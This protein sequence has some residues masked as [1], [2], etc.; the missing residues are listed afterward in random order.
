MSWQS[1]CNGA[2]CTSSIELTCSRTCGRMPIAHGHAYASDVVMRTQ[3]FDS[4]LAFLGLHTGYMGHGHAPGLA[5]LIIRAVGVYAYDAGG[6]PL[7]STTCVG[8]ACTSSI[9]L[10]CSRACGRMP[11]P[12]NAHTLCE[13]EKGEYNTCVGAACT[14]SIELTCSRTCG[15]MPIAH[16]HAYANDVVHAHTTIRFLIG[17]SRIAYR[18]HGTWDMHQAQPCS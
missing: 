18:L 12:C 14:S 6:V 3:Q 16:G 5:L 13:Y 10:T 9:E 7:R 1:P 17:I 8:A 4:S 2:A 15:R 11:I